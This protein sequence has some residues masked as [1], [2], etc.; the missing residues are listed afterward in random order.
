[1]NKIERPGGQMTLDE[2]LL[3][4]A[5]RGFSGRAAQGAAQVL[6]K[7]CTRSSAARD[8]GIHPSAIS[9]LL[10]KV[11]VEETCKCCGHTHRRVQ[12]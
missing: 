1:M 3:A 9:K 11:E 10:A 7:G 4:L 12:L 6:V 2:A 8:L 5:R